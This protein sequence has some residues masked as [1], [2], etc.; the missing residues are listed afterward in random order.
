MT[1]PP[2]A[3]TGLVLPSPGGQPPDGPVAPVG[4]SA[5]QPLVAFTSDM[6]GD[7]WKRPTSTDR[8]ELASLSPSLVGSV[9]TASS[10]WPA[11]ALPVTAA[12]PLL[13]WSV[14]SFA[15]P[16]SATDEVRQPEGTATCTR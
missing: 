8:L 16:P 12:P 14:S 7:G 10:T 1:A 6:A 5:S 13:S 11:S 9:P 3:T 2:V 4:V 15:S